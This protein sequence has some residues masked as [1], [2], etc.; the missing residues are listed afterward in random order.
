LDA[1][2]YE[3]LPNLP[4]SP[5]KAL[6]FYRNLELSRNSSGANAPAI[7]KIFTPEF[8]GHLVALAHALRS[9][10]NGEKEKP[11]VANNK[12]KECVSFK[13]NTLA[14]SIAMG[15]FFIIICK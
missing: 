10:Q 15:Y 13:K 5:G 3:F 1:N 8:N 14:L 11:I 7:C 12:A 6:Y 9:D 4:L 2:S